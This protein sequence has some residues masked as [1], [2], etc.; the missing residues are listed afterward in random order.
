M[1]ADSRESHV[2]MIFQK[3]KF[4]CCLA[5][6]YFKETQL[7]RYFLGMHGPILST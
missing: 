7:H 3:C 6:F 5:M 2:K 1:A 4:L